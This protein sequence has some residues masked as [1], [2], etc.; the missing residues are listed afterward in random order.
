M[1]K[2]LS[3]IAILAI[4]FITTFSI[5][6]YAAALTGINVTTTKTTIKPGENVTVDI[7]FGEELGAYTF[8]GMTKVAKAE[9]KNNLMMSVLIGS[10]V[11]RL[12][13]V[14]TDILRK[15]K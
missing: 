14:L 7:E 13:M 4:A 11:G 1:K 10:D 9:D 12:Y 3:I 5:N 6:V 8:E 15:E 2:T